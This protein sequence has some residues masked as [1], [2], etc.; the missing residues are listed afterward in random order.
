MKP[1]LKEISGQSL[2]LGLAIWLLLKR[3]K[4]GEGIPL[5]GP[6]A[7]PLIVPS[8]ASEVIPVI[9][10]EID[11]LYR[12]YVAATA[13]QESNFNH[14]E[15]GTADTVWIGGAG[16]IGLCQILP[17]TGAGLGF[18]IEDLKDIRKNMKACELYFREAENSWNGWYDGLTDELRQQWGVPFSVY[19]LARYYNGGPRVVPQPG[20][21]T[22]THPNLSTVYADQW[23]RRYLALDEYYIDFVVDGGFI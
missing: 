4:L 7:F 18:S 17:A 16:E 12:H 10:E 3:T 9:E 2:L 19:E 11:P 23:L 15:P 5:L 1:T 6:L 13:W 14:I 20:T 8:N 22:Q 21:L